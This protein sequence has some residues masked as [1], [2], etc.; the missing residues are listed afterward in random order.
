VFANSARD[1]APHRVAL[2][3]LGGAATATVGAVVA[4][5]VGW[6]L[7]D[8]RGFG[9]DEEDVCLYPILRSGYAGAL[10]AAPLGVYAAGEL[11][12][13]DG[14]PWWTFGVSWSL[15][16]ASFAVARSDAPEVASLLL[17]ITTF[18]TGIVVYELTSNIKIDQ[19]RARRRVVPNVSPF[20]GP[21]AAGI[22]ISGAL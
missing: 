17:G 8:R 6:R 2:E 9:H 15:A 21:T 22:M 3:V 13:G 1:R 4:A 18:A 5:R 16:A 12:G 19:R 20:A 7:C 14:S 10:L 11:A